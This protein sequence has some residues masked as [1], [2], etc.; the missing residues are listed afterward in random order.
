MSEPRFGNWREPYEQA[1]LELDPAL[2]RQ[3]VL[4]AE[5]AIFGRLQQLSMDGNG[6]GVKEERMAINDA[7]ANLRVLQQ[8]KLQ[9]PGW[10]ST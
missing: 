7:I 6:P 8:K 4:D 3:K 5:A 10:K 2:L 1:L 9:F